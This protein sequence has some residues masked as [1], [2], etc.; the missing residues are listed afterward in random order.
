[1]KPLD[2]TLL[3]YGSRG[4]VEPFLALADGLTAAGHRVTLAAPERLRFLLDNNQVQYQGLP[5]DPGQLARAFREH[6]GANLLKIFGAMTRHV[7]PIAAKVF[8]KAQTSSRG[9]DVILHSFLMTDGGH[10][11]ARRQG[12]VDISAQFFPVFQPTGQF[13]APLFPD[14]PVGDGYRRLTHHLSTFAFR[15]GGRLMYRF[16]RREHPELPPLAKW[17]FRKQTE[18][19]IPKFFAFSEHVIPRPPDWPSHAVIT[20]YWHRTRPEKWTPHQK[21]AS[22]LAT[23]DR[24][25]FISLGSMMPQAGEEVIGLFSAP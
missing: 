18:E 25:V 7:L 1:M 12:A 2:I 6:A 14:L 23:N 22:F 20:G 15:Y 16:L 19:T 21:L 13:P 4:D 10:T 24:P 8:K 3:T 11:L 17:P 9:A 5:G